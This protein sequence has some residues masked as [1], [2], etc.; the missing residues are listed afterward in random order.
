M[1]TVTKLY[2][3]AFLSIDGNDVS[4]QITQLNLTYES[5]T[6]DDTTMGDDTTSLTGT[7]KNWSI[8][9]TA[10]SDFSNGGLDSVL[11]NLVGVAGVPIIF[12]P[13]AG[14][15]STSNPEYTAN[16]MLGNQTVASGS[17]GDLSTTPFSIVPSKGS[18]SADLVRATS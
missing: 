2:T 18:G 3:D 11:F 17:V 10:F 15:V 4:N 14:S 16:G 6:A 5:Q 13:D 1:A 8:E 9:A 7:L 12:R